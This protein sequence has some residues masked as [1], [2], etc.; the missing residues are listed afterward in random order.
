MKLPRDVSGH[1]LARALSKFGYTI[2]RQSGSHMRLTSNVKGM[3]HHITIPVHDPLRVGTFS[4][5]LSDVSN[6]LEMTREELL[7]TLFG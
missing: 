6:H 2:T 4:Q 1:E 5:I 7:R 3:E